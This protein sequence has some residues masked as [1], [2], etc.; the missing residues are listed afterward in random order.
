MGGGATEMARVGGLFEYCTVVDERGVVDALPHIAEDDEELL[1]DLSHFCIP[2]TP[3]HSNS[4]T[5]CWSFVLTDTRGNRRYGTCLAF[6]VQVDAGAPPSVCA[7]CLLSRFSVFDTARALLCR[8]YTVMVS[9]KSVAEGSQARFVCSG[10]GD[11]LTALAT[12]IVR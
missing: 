10:G 6:R 11:A 2:S 8:L 12:A 5:V 4:G 9:Q 1:R 3:I 7:L